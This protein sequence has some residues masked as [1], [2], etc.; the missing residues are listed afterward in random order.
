MVFAY[1]GRSFELNQRRSNHIHKS[2][3]ELS[4]RTPLSR[5]SVLAR[6]LTHGEAAH[7]EPSPPLPAAESKA[8]GERRRRLLRFRFDRR[9]LKVVV[10][11]QADANDTA[12]DTYGGVGGIFVLEGELLVP[13]SSSDECAS[14]VLVLMHPA[15]VLNM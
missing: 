13:S 12:D 14:T 7:A 8:S 2:K 6:H 3:M 9:P 4:R 1:I 15:A 5:L 11:E 10:Q